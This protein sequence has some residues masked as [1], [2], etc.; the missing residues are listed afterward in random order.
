MTESEIVVEPKSKRPSGRTRPASRQ[1]DALMAMLQRVDARMD[2]LERREQQ[3]PF[4]EREPDPLPQS[5]T[6]RPELLAT[7][8]LQALHSQTSS[9]EP[10]YQL[11]SR[12]YNHPNRL[13][14]RPDGDVVELQGSP[15]ALEM[16][17]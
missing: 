12:A 5:A 8:M 15:Q 7:P 4:V 1:P 17:L 10:D 13:Y 14:M 11:A 6:A 3:S 16:Y 2:A 9:P